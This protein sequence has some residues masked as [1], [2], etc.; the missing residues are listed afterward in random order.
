MSKTILGLIIAAAIG[1]AIEG[2]EE[3]PRMITVIVF[4]SLAVVLG[5]WIL[6]SGLLWPNRSSWRADLLNAT[7][8]LEGKEATKWRTD[9]QQQ[10]GDSFVLDIRKRPNKAI[11]II[12]KAASM[13][14]K[15][16]RYWNYGKV[17]L[18]DKV[19]FMHGKDALDY[20]KKWKVI[21]SGASGILQEWEQ[22]DSG[23]RHNISFPINPPELV[24]FIV[25]EIIE[26][27]P[28]HHWS[29][30]DIRIREVRLF[31]KYWKV[32]IK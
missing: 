20:P 22:N 19:I 4:G 1:A 3:T 8:Y 23:P 32:D 31:G 10:A 2:L 29:V 13:I 9:R 25:V 11:Y 7:D 16:I 30:S 21:L 5:L 27:R 17:R 24:D 12:L 18:I 28:R 15:R 26:P 14:F 6:L